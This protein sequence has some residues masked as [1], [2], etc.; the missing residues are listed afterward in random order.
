MRFIFTFIVFLI[1]I[2]CNAQLKEIG[3]KSGF[4]NSLI[5]INNYKTEKGQS[6]YTH[7]FAQVY[8]YNNFSIQTGLGI[9]ENNSTHIYKKS[10]GNGD[11]AKFTEDL[12]TR[13]FFAE[14]D[15]KYKLLIPELKTIFPYLLVGAQYAIL[16]RQNDNIS[17]ELN[18]HKFQG[19]LGI[20]FDM[21][22][23]NTH[24]FF[25][26]NKLLNFNTNYSRNPSYI[27]LENAG[28]YM[29]GLKLPINTKKS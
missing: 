28:V 8:H 12:E 3:I 2:N 9:I 21:D 5:R 11:S 23:N 25:E 18:K 4:T 19:V 15:S 17:F 22:L 10:I 24:I 29:L 26:Y 7:A 14:V 13:S 27:F 6:F 20:G 1:A 16:N